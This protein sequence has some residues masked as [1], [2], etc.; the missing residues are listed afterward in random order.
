MTDLVENLL[1]KLEYIMSWNFSCIHCTCL[2]STRIKVHSFSER[3]RERERNEARNSCYLNC[4]YYQN[5]LAVDILTRKEDTTL[6]LARSCT[7]CS[8]FIGCS[9]T[10]STVQT[11]GKLTGCL[12]SSELRS[13]LQTLLILS[14]S[15][16]QISQT[17]AR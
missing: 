4:Y 5:P 16:P 11:R 15:S 1:V 9:I 6:L 14:I 3:K 8:T 13:T 2:A 10:W 17:T 12:A 7:K